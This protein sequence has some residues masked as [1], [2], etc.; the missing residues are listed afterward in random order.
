MSDSFATPWTIA[1]QATL[2]MGFFR[3]EYWSGLP[4]P[5]PGDLPNPGIEPASP[6]LQADSLPLSHCRSQYTHMLYFTVKMMPMMG[7]FLV[8]QGLRLHFPNAG[9][10]GSI[11]DQGTR[12]HTPQLRVL[13]AAMKI[14]DPACLTKT[15]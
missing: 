1:S 8:V 10:R 6:A 14:E 2:S 9:D 7:V 13:H 12:S 11:P 15:Q 3:Q 5:P 4:F